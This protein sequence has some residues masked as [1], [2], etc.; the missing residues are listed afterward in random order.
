MPLVINTNLLSVNAQRNLSKTE[1]IIQ[2]AMQR[3]SSGL[4]INSAKDDAAGLAISTRMTTQIRGLTVA[5]RNANDG[6]SIL[7]T[8]EG[9]MD[10]MVNNLQRMYELAEQAASYN[11]TQDRNS[12][13]Q[14]V[15]QLIDELSRIVNQTRFNGQKL[16]AGG[17]S[18]DIQVGLEV[19]ETINI[20][21]SNVSPATLGIAT[22]YATIN[23]LSNSDLATRIARAYANASS[24]TP[25]LEGVSLGSQFA[26]N[27]LS[28]EKINTINSYTSSTGVT[29][30]GYGNGLVGV[31]F[32]PSA[33]S[34]ADIAAGALVI[35]GI[36]IDAAAAGS[37][38]GDLANNLV[39]AINAKTAQHGVTAVRVD[40][41]NGDGTS[42]DS[43]I[44]LINRTGAAITVTANDSVDSDITN[45][46]SAGTTSVDAGAN[47]AIVL[48]DSL[49]DT[50]VS[51]DAAATGFSITGVSSATATLSD[52]TVNAQTV[53]TAA[54]ANLAMLVFKSAMDSINSQ[55]SI[56]GAKQNR[57]ESVVR[58][59]D[60]I[61]ENITA[62]RSRIVDADF[63][64]ET[65][66]L[67]KGLIMQQAGISVLAQAN[68]VPQQVLALLGR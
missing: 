57:F 34:S 66:N 19:N 24:A 10:E 53:T 8:A 52:S 58:N 15:S 63:A 45:F 12:L 39:N 14:E 7:Q 42:N 3:L 28:S 22:N 36:S 51:F 17:F 21:I 30:F 54:S 35:N 6:I 55:R 25:T 43:A 38:L 37:T 16:L 49:G 20:S 56:L 4:R 18:A 48:N 46:F 32:D 64:Q 5:I 41:L 61:R 13:N 27:T 26:A 31:S 44:V 68:T 29:A 67:T 9:A 65:A 50:T 60:N 23:N 62:A 1:P 33:V 40:D 47:G 2:T 59:L 11:T